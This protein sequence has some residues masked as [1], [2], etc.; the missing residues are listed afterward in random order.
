MAVRAEGWR[1]GWTYSHGGRGSGY[2]EGDPRTASELEAAAA[3]HQ[4]AC[5]RRGGAEFFSRDPDRWDRVDPEAHA[6]AGWQVR[7]LR[8]A[9]MHKLIEMRCEVAADVDGDG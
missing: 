4:A 6:L 9:A 3:I 5:E 1:W 2:R 8:T 7:R